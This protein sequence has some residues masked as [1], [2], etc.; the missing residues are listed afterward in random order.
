[1]PPLPS[2]TNNVLT[3]PLCCFCHVHLLFGFGKSCCC[4]QAPSMRC[5]AASRARPLLA[6]RSSGLDKRSRHV[7]QY[8]F[9]Q[10]KKR[11]VQPACECDGAPLGRSGAFRSSSRFSREAA[12]RISKADCQM[13][14][15]V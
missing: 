1:M 3:Y 11:K 4:D 7:W 6:S 15:V 2:P 9:N 14:M 10:K 13:E 5:R 12:P 8:S